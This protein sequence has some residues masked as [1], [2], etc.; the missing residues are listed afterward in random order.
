MFTTHPDGGQ[1]TVYPEHIRI[2]VGTQFIVKSQVSVWSSRNKNF[3]KRSKP[4]YFLARLCFSGSQEPP[5]L[6]LATDCWM[7]YIPSTP[8]LTLGYMVF[9]SS[10]SFPS[11]HWIMVS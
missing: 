6:L 7:K 2:V 11:A 4:A 10:N 5:A 3:E 8:S 9:I 1:T